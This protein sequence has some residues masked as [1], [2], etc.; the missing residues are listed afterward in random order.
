MVRPQSVH[1]A[2]SDSACRAGGLKRQ[3]EREVAAKLQEQRVEDVMT[4]TTQI[5]DAIASINGSYVLTLND[6][7]A[8]LANQVEMLQAHSTKQQQE[9]VENTSKLLLSE[10][11]RIRSMVSSG[12]KERLV[13]SLRE[14]A[15]KGHAHVF[16]AVSH[17]VDDALSGT[18]AVLD[19]EL[20]AERNLNHTLVV[21]LRSYAKTLL[22]EVKAATVRAFQAE[23]EVIQ[24][25]VLVAKL[26]AACAFAENRLIRHEQE[27][28]ALMRVVAQ[29]A[30][31]S[32][33]AESARANVRRALRHVRL[34]EQHLG[35]DEIVA[36]VQAEVA[37]ASPGTFSESRRGSEPPPPPDPSLRSTAPHYFALKMLEHKEMTL[38]DLVDSWQEQE[39]RIVEAEE[40]YRRLEDVV[41]RVQHDALVVHQRYLAEK[42]RREIADRRITDM[43]R[44]RIQPQKDP[45]ILEEV[46][47]LRWAYT[48]VVDD[49]AQLAVNLKVC[50]DELQHS[51]ENVAR[52]S[53]EVLQ[54]RRDAETD[55]VAIT[56][57]ELRSEYAA[58]VRGLEEAST[59]AQVQLSLA[60][61][62]SM[63]Y[64]V[65]ATEATAALRRAAQANA[66]LSA[67]SLQVSTGDSRAAA[68]A[69][70]PWREQFEEVETQAERVLSKTTE[71]KE[72]AN[73]HGELFDAQ[74]KELMRQ[75]T[76]MRESDRTTGS[77]ALT[78]EAM[79]SRT[80]VSSSIGAEESVEKMN[81][82]LSAS[83][84]AL[85]EA[86]VLLNSSLQSVDV[87]RSHLVDTSISDA[88]Y[89]SELMAEV[90]RVT[91]ERDH[92][93]AQ[94]RVCQGLLEKNHVTVVERALMHD[95]PVEDSL[96]VAEAT[97]RIEVLKN[98]LAAA[99][100]ICDRSLTEVKQVTAEKEGVELRFSEMARALE[101][102]QGHTSRLT[103]KLQSS[104]ARESAL[105]EKN[106]ALQTQITDLVQIS[107]EPGD[108]AGVSS[109]TPH[110][111]AASLT[112][113]F[114][115][116][117]GMLGSLGD[118]I[119]ALRRERTEGARGDAHIGTGNNRGS[120]AEGADDAMLVDS[121]SRSGMMSVVRLVKDTLHKAGLLKASLKNVAGA[122]A[123]YLCDAAASV[124]ENSVVG[125]GDGVTSSA[126]PAP[127]PEAKL[128]ALEYRSSLAEAK[129]TGMAAE[130]L[131]MRERLQ[132]FERT[133]AEME[134]ANQRLLTISKSVMEKQNALKT[135]NE[136]LRAQVRALTEAATAAK[137][138]TPPPPPL[139]EHPTSPV[140]ITAL[141]RSLVD[142]PAPDDTPCQHVEEGMPVASRPTQ[143]ATTPPVAFSQVD[144][145]CLTDA[146]M[147][148]RREQDEEA[149]GRPESV[150]ANVM[151]TPPSEFMREERVLETTASLDA[152]EDAG[153]SASL[154]SE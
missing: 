71:I 104:L 49:A 35:L 44:E 25:D 105:M 153:E 150:G 5:V 128:R 4:H 26:R 100:Q 34:L 152:E 92:L 20:S 124:S 41:K 126:V 121:L 50:R 106:A 69:R 23:V 83:Q 139:T 62:V 11:A 6:E 101:V 7:R 123:A 64:G 56:I 31:K 131:E 133:A 90:R 29:L 36:A 75:W 125:D 72:F 146:S 38:T 151:G 76:R 130:R 40:R 111:T 70:A 85:R 93:R 42:Q 102:L 68:T 46:Q 86:L 15:D 103:E 12:V 154:P 141:A 8:R 19:G 55:Q 60:Q 94:V 136:Q 65:A 43:V 22:T 78:D 77:C 37:S 58:R 119:N 142:A 28:D 87:E 149:E 116:L 96:N 14:E 132:R 32:R 89:V 107:E 80:L 13:E 137:P 95:V 127:P 24:R 140:P 61:Q 59:R 3:R 115:S 82:V 88:Q 120:G 51:Q 1:T 138:A 9:Q 98:Q 48:E 53:A 114:S 79:E 73:A 63:Q 112:D 118:E 16:E 52:L 147:T 135:E 66:E 81:A 2:G 17:H 134:A 144:N 129:L 143:P 54:L 67:A 148:S 145:R 27:V 10:L 84:F 47:R 91:A 18:L 110:A 97:E 30:E 57:Q 33:Y 109:T 74:V 122:Q 45:A 108:E 117:Q 113:L 99:K 39:S 21:Q